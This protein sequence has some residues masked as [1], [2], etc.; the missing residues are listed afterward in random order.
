MLHRKHKQLQKDHLQLLK[1]LLEA[2]DQFKSRKYL[3]FR[4]PTPQNRPFTYENRAKRQL[5]TQGQ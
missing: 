4:Q 2:P 1:G 3:W 5:P